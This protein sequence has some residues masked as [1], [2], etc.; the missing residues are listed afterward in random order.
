M[1]KSFFACLLLITGLLAAAPAWSQ[2]YKCVDA[3]GHPTFSNVPA[4]KNAKNCTRLQIESDAPP[5]TATTTG[6]T[7]GAAAN[8]TPVGYPRVEPDAQ[9][10]RDN[11]RR[12]IL[13]QELASAQQ[14]LDAAKAR[15]AEEEKIRLGNEKNAQK[16]EDR[17]QPFREEVA[18]NERN[19]AEINREISRLK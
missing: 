2:I 1:K 14:S 10:A 19:L 7:R 13:N 12:A 9:K 11:D 8:P 17:L 16:R 18:R 5:S 6:R 15:L 4:D 3:D